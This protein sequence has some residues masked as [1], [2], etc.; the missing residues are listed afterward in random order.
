MDS[1]ACSL[2]AIEPLQE[3]PSDFSHVLTGP[4]RGGCHL[5]FSSSPSC[6]HAAD[7]AFDAVA[8]SDFFT[9]VKFVLR[10]QYMRCQ[11][12]AGKMPVEHGEPRRCQFLV[13]CPTHLPPIVLM[14]CATLVYFYAPHIR[15]Y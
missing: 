14:Q 10:C 1:I 5:C 13:S 2:S 4:S 7:M 9:Y 6:A 3:L 11:Y 12:D 8:K 15:Q